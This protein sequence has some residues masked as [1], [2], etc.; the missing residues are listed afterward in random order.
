MAIALNETITETKV[1]SQVQITGF[2]INYENLE[3]KSD[4]MTLLEDGTPHQRGSATTRDA[5]EI[6][7]LMNNIELAVR[8]DGKTLDEA[9]AEVAYAFV[10]SKF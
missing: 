1:V 5:T 4:Y 8:D 7:T 10:L 2:S 3:L 6:S 9:S